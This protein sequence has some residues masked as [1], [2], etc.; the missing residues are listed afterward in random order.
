MDSRCTLDGLVTPTDATAAI[1][2]SLYLQR[3]GFRVVVQQDKGEV[4]VYVGRRDAPVTQDARAT[5]S[6][7]RRYDTTACEDNREDMEKVTES[8]ARR[9]AD[10]ESADTDKLAK[11]LR[12]SQ[13]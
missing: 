1:N 7:F 8:R 3:R 12:I 13:K 4:T 2:L 6:T 11:L 10:K 9:F 5:A